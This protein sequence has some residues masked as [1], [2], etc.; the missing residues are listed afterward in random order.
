M[1]LRKA[2]MCSVC[3]QLSD[4]LHMFWLCSEV[5]TFWKYIEAL[6]RKCSDQKFCLIFQHIVYGLRIENRKEINLILNYALFSI[7]KCHKITLATTKMI[8]CNDLKMM[9]TY[10]L[11][12]RY[13]IEKYQD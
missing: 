1:G 13:D 8:K 6:I 9:F 7:Y 4:L 3:N 5:Q 12:N 11:K 2:D 10:V